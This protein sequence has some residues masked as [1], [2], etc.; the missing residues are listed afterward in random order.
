M[1]CRACWVV[2]WLVIG[3]KQGL[4]ARGRWF[5]YIG[6]VALILTPATVLIRVLESV[7]RLP[8]YYIAGLPVSTTLVLLFTILYMIWAEIGIAR[9]ILR[10]LG[11]VFDSLVFIGIHAALVLGLAV[12]FYVQQNGYL[13]LVMAMMA[14]GSVHL[15]RRAYLYAPVSA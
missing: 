6:L 9:T 11:S 1:I 7:K 14:A 2:S 13:P 3:V 12:G 4:V 5:D 10:R 8:V 15:A